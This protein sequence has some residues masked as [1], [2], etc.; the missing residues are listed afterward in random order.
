MIYLLLVKNYTL[1]GADMVSI[2]W[3]F[4]IIMGIC[5]S[6]ISGNIETINSTILTSSNKAF[7][8][9]TSLMPAI[10]L[11]SGIMKIAENAGILDKFARVLKLNVPYHVL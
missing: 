2:L 11:W 1:K 7:K 6:L 3:T 9:I 5:Y 8:L 10:V 4:L